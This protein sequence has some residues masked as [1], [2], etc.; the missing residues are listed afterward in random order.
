MHLRN[1]TVFALW[2][3][4]AADGMAAETSQR[5]AVSVRQYVLDSFVGPY[6]AA[7][8]G[9]VKKY[10]TMSKDYG[11]AIAS[12]T[13]RA[14]ETLDVLLKTEQFRSLTNSEAPRDLVEMSSFNADMQRQTFGSMSTER[15][16]QALSELR[17]MT[18]EKIQGALHALLFYT[19]PVVDMLKS[20]TTR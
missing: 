4:L 14:P 20:A 3:L 15:C 1:F 7:A 17:D 13:K 9:C 19:K 10:P 16:T 11:E 6:K 18:G 8:D 12:L 5:T 2:L